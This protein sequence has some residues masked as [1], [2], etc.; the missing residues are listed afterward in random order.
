MI[1]VYHLWIYYLK[2]DIKQNV[3]N[4]VVLWTVETSVL[5]TKF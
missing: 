2:Q 4:S 5:K 3:K 1:V